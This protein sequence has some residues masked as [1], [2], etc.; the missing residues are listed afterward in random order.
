MLI[1]SRGRWWLKVTLMVLTL[2]SAWAIWSSLESYFGHP[3]PA[4]IAQFNGQRAALFWC[5]IEEPDPSNKGAIFLWMRLLDQAKPGA[6]VYSPAGPILYSFPYDREAHATV[7]GFLDNIVANGGS[8]I[9]IAFSQANGQ[10]KD[11]ERG[12]THEA[13]G[14][15]AGK[16]DNRGSMSLGKGEM[17]RLPDPKLPEKLQP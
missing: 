7:Q 13:G 16:L 3:R 9:Y 11:R 17:Y 1:G 12:G 10:G 15:K 5:R 14:G 4:T 6:F 2:F 8:P